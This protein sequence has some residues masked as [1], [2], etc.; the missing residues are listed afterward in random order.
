MLVY[1]FLPLRSQPVP[2][3]SYAEVPFSSAPDF[4]GTA[5]G[6]A[7]VFGVIT[8]KDLLDSVLK[9]RPLSSQVSVFLWERG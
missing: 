7:K 3:L 8:H 5:D 6:L 1:F 2:P 4:L 9:S